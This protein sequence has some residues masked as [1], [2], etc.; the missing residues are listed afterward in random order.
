MIPVG[1]SFTPF[2][3]DIDSLGSTPKEWYAPDFTKKTGYS[4]EVT[5]EN[6]N[7]KITISNQK[8]EYSD[9]GI[10]LQSFPAEIYKNKRIRFTSDIK[11]DADENSFANLYLS[12]SVGESEKVYELVNVPMGTK[13]WK[14]YKIS[15]TIPDYAKNV[16]VGIYFVGKGSAHFDNVEL[17]MLGSANDGN[18]PPFPIVEKEMDNM[19]AFL[20]LYGYV[21]YF[22]PSDQGI[23]VDWEKFVINGLEYV[24]K[25][26]KSIELAFALEQF[27]KPIAPLVKV[28]PTDEISSKFSVPDELLE[29]NNK[30]REVTFWTHFGFS[31]PHKNQSSSSLRTL[32]SNPYYLKQGVIGQ[33]I[34][35]KE[36]AG[37]KVRITCDIQNKNTG[38]N[39]K[40]FI[41]L[42]QDRPG[43]LLGKLQEAIDSSKNSGKWSKIT[44]ETELQKDVSFLSFGC[45]VQGFSNAMFDDFTVEIFEENEYKIAQLYNADFNI[46]DAVGKPEGWN[47][48]TSTSPVTFTIES[49]SYTKSNSYV[50]IKTEPYTYDLSYDPSQTLVVPLES[51][52]T[53]M[54]P[55]ALYLD[56]NGHTIPTTSSVNL[57]EVKPEGFTS[58]HTDKISRIA[59]SGILWNILKHFYPYQDQE[60]V[61]WTRT[62]MNAISGVTVAPEELEMTH[63]LKRIV[64]E[65]N[66]GQSRI[67]KMPVKQSYS[68]PFLW[69]MIGD[70][71]MITDVLPD[72]LL[73]VKAGDTVAGINGLPLNDYLTYEKEIVSSPTDQ[74]KE[75]RALAEIRNGEKDSIVQ[76]QIRPYKERVKPFTVSIPYVIDSR[77]MVE[78]RLKPIQRLKG[79]LLYIDITR[80]EESEMNELIPTFQSYKGIIFDVRGVPT[81]TAKFLTSFS[82]KSIKSPIWLTPVITYPDF[83]RTE[84][85]TSYFEIAGSKRNSK[86]KAVFLIDARSIGYAETILSMVETSKLGEIIGSSSGGTN[87]T[88]QSISLPLSYFASFTTTKVLKNNKLPFHGVGI[89]PTIPIKRTIKGVITGND[90][91]LES[92]VMNLL[93]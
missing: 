15:T 8:G 76:L 59:I 14:T 57:I 65:I 10:L 37:K 46:V 81:V 27:F 2:K 42:R 78:P 34:Q 63:V 60:L 61:R 58:N 75:I 40:S 12:Y 7:Q 3:F 30:G 48:S 53:C 69:D 68:L 24:E 18:S 51:G 28:F 77:L 16:T 79:G 72:S 1:S 39:G 32:R 44:I 93:K 35:A 17:I 21:R 55:I 50:I 52:V 6:S 11:V 54:V 56:E 71:L 19:M 90:E 87:G 9:Y 25:I 64:A 67:W 36:F 62:L 4:F 29:K 31:T 88:S 83:L 47:I 49:K 74:W 85:D 38:N 20:R 70:Q 13:S 33:T 84:F 73:L 5:S 92:A 91:F 45:G 22:H 66:D 86:T 26:D 82:T 80:L 89:A 43:N 23:N 41:W